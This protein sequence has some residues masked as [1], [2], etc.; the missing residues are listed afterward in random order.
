MHFNYCNCNVILQ[1]VFAAIPLAFVLPGLCYIKLADSKF[2][3][4][5]KI[6]ALL[7]ALFGLAVAVNS[8]VAFALVGIPKCHPNDK[9]MKYCTFVD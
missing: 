2:C 8:I 9:E 5:D 7:L 4:W 6:S 3:S 1:G